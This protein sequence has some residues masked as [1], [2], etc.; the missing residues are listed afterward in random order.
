MLAS[1][2]RCMLDVDSKEI[3]PLPESARAVGSRNLKYHSR[4]VDTQGLKTLRTIDIE[5]KKLRLDVE[6]P[7]FGLSVQSSEEDAI[8]YLCEKHDIRELWYSIVEN[9]FQN[10][11]PLVAWQPD[12]RVDEYIVVE[13]NRRLAAVKTLL[14]PSLVARFSKTSVPEVPPH[15]IGSLRTLSVTV[16]ADKD[17]A[18]EYIGFRHVNGARN[19]EPLPKAKFGLK[20]LEK[21][22]KD[23]SISS[24]KKRVEILA[25]QIGDQPTQ[26][27]R[28]L[29]S[30][31]VIEQ[32]RDLGLIQEDFLE[33]TRND[34]SHLYSIL[35]NPDTRKYIGL[36]EQ[37]L[38]AE[39]IVDHPIHDSYIGNL[40]KLMGWLFGSVDG[41]KPSI[42]ERQGQ[43]RPAH[44]KIIAS[45]DALVALETTGDFSYAKQISGVDADDWLSLAYGLDR[46]AQRVWEGSSS[47]IDDLPLKDREKV[48]RSIEKAIS[49]LQ[50]ISKLLS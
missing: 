37:A 20:L 17:S 7:R 41:S 39:Q 46:S 28:N 19:W 24:D 35:S 11:E 15:H 25:R 34:F 22:R 12:P 23:H 32:A 5:P 48:Q 36:G 8:Q 3:R 50:K 27:T 47:V 21:L 40:R 29:F 1:L 18:D 16:I 33:Q 14:D 30:Y 38:Q 31:K 6:N 26:I 4:I 45:P 9:G 10:Y 2:E 44:Q 43:D 13:G 42:I 49:S